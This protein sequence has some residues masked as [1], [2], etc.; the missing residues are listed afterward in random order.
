MG[1]HFLD[2]WTELI[3]SGSVSDFVTIVWVTWSRFYYETIKRKIDRR[4]IWVSVW[5]KTNRWRWGSTRLEY[6]VWLCYSSFS[7]LGIFAQF[8][9][10]FEVLIL[11]SFAQ[12]LL[13]SSGTRRERG[14]EFGTEGH[15]QYCLLW[16]NKESQRE[17][18]YMSIGVMKD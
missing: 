3:C 6:K 11:G 2:R 1:S 5:W 15:V 8:L 4:L 17:D 10:L 14:G 12:F 16:I 13:L 18:L 9:E 7:F